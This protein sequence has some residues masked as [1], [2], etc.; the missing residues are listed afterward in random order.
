MRK[1]AVLLAV[2]VA[3]ASAFAQGTVTFA[4]N[5]A[6]AT[7]ADRLVK[8]VGGASLTGTT[9]FAQ[10]FFGA[11][12]TAEGSLTAVT[13]T[14]A[15]RA[16]TTASPGT[17]VGGSRTLT[18][19]TSGQTATLQ[20]RVWDSAAFASYDAAV[21]GGGKIGSSA[22]FDY[23]VPAAGSPPAAFFM[24]GLRTFTLTQVPEPTT[25]ALGAMGLAGLLAIRRRK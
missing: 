16:S 10:L 24:E 22:L 23:T 21:A 25:L 18:G 12:G 13:P 5:S 3:T 4:N 17:L 19:I 9:F 8:D 14:A 11:Q 15:F 7:V 6:Y 1:L 20:V 2:T